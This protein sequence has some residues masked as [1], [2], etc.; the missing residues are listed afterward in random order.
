MCLIESSEES[1]L[2]E[3]IDPLKLLL[4]FLLDF[5]KI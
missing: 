5:N 2:L 3:F 1:E 4:L